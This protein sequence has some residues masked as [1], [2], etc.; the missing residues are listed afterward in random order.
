MFEQEQ[1]MLVVSVLLCLL[2]FDGSVGIN[3]RSQIIILLISHIQRASFAELLLVWIFI[4]LNAYVTKRECK[5]RMNSVCLNYAAKI[6][7]RDEKNK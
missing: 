7:I 6:N 2:Q 4:L 3:R 5:E 1:F